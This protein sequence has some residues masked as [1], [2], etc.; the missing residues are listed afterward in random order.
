MKKMIAFCVPHD[1]ARR[2][3]SRL[4]AAAKKETEKKRKIAK[5]AGQM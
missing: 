5:K 4:L 2:P 3:L 1:P